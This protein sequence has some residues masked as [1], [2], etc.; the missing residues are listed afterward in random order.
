MSWL[1]RLVGPAVEEVEPGEARRRQQAGAILIDVREPEEWAA[2]HAP[3][4]RHM[5]LGQLAQRLRSLPRDRELL[6]ICRSGNR[7]SRAVQLAVEAGRTR[8]VNVGGGLLAWAR[9]GLPVER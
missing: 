3:G 1:K 2:G 8:A 9:A 4:A 5:P 7:S 6:F